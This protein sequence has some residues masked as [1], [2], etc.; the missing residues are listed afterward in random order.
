LYQK[1]KDITATKTEIDELLESGCEM[2]ALDATMRKR[3]R[4]LSLAELV[5][6]TR[7]KSPTVELM[8]DIASIED[9]MLKN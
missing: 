8:A 6:Y 7:G 1:I 3:P 5:S 2:I 9:A 4:N